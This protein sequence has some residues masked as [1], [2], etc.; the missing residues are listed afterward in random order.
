MNHRHR[1]DHPN[2]ADRHGRRHAHEGFGPEGSG[3]RGHGRHGHEHEHGHRGGHRHGGG[4]Q[5]RGGRVLDHGELRTLVLDLIAEKPR[6][7]YELIRAIEDATGGG[8]APSPGVIYPTLTL[9]EEI[10]HASV[11]ET[12]GTRKLYAATEAGRAH[13]ASSKAAVDVARA[14]LAEMSE[15][16]ASSEAPPILR[17]MENLK[18]ALRLRT[19]RGQLTGAQ[20]DA[21][22]TTLDDAARAVERS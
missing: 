7:G 18:M 3:E 1:H 11:A 22:A 19:S 10:G 21:I 17:A 20:I 13:L 9:L 2:R 16:R 12:D 8:Y 14:R 15:S 6:H 4:R 5:R